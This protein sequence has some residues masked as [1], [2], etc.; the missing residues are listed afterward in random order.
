MIRQT[1]MNIVM[2]MALFGSGCTLSGPASTATEFTAE[3]TGNAERP[4]PVSTQAQGSGTFALNEAQTELSF[5]IEA[6]RFETDVVGAHFHLSLT[7]AGGF[8][9]IV[10]DITGTIVDQGNG[11]VTLE[12]VWPVTA[13]DV[14]NLRLGYIYVNIHTVEHQAGEIRGNLVHAE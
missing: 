4:N 3:L 2:G 14:Q 8:G 1:A 12:G 5:S 9:G 7:G 11:L 13:E 6:S 10:F